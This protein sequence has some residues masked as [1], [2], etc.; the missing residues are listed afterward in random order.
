MH[1]LLLSTGLFFCFPQH[2]NNIYQIIDNSCQGFICREPEYFI[3]RYHFKIQHEK[4][5]SNFSIDVKYEG[6]RFPLHLTDTIDKNILDSKVTSSSYGNDISYAIHYVI[7]EIFNHLPASRDSFSRVQKFSRTVN[8]IT[9]QK[10]SFINYF[11]P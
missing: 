6:D 1:R 9:I 3:H 10:D 5:V 4:E 11:K 7:K 8:G 2:A